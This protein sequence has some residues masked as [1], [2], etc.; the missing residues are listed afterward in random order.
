MQKLYTKSLISRKLDVDKG[1]YKALVT[2][3]R[4]YSPEFETFMNPRSGWVKKRDSKNTSNVH[5]CFYSIG[6]FLRDCL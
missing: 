4:Q 1:L 2:L 5:H 6:K 3:L